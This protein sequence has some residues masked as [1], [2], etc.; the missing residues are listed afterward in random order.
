MKR[1]LFAFLF[2]SAF[3]FVGS[4]SNVVPT[5]AT[6]STT[7]FVVK[8]LDK[9]KNTFI[10]VCIAYCDYNRTRYIYVA[11]TCAAADAGCIAMV[12]NAQTEPLK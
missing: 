2:M 5:I 6:K 7:T 10:C 3:S 4:A 9:Y 1:V 11:D 8:Q 12:K